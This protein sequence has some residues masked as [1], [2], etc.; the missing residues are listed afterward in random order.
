MVKRLTNPLQELDLP[1]GTLMNSAGAR[2]AASLDA[3]LRAAGFADLRSSHAAP[4]MVLDAEGTRPSEL[5]TRAHMSKQAMGEL[6]A[7]LVD[8]GYLE[9]LPD[10]A[11]RRARL[12][13]PTARGWRAVD[14]GHKVITDFDQWLEEQLGAEEVAQ[15]R[16]ALRLIL[17]APTLLNNKDH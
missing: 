8:H 3:A 13:R 9:V 16:R 12:V 1:L 2:L 4:F 11:D 15:L 6:V 17:Q 7:Y 14:T 5:A 10:P